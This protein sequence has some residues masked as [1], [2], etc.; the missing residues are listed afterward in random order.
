MSWISGMGLV[1]KD[2]RNAAM[3]LIDNWNLALREGRS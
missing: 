2:S 3:G 1:D